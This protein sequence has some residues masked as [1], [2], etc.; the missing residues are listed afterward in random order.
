MDSI[1]TTYIIPLSVLCVGYEH[2]MA[3]GTKA[4]DIYLSGENVECDPPEGIS[5][6]EIFMDPSDGL[7]KLYIEFE[8]PEVHPGIKI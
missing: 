5:N 2:E 7:H 8:G 4:H 6:G 3:P 1:K